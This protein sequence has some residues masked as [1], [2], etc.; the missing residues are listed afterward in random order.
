ML[1]DELYSKFNEN[2]II[3]DINL[4]PTF[5]YNYNNKI[6]TYFPDVYVKSIN[7]IY[8]VK[9]NYTFEKE[10]EKNMN[11]FEAVKKSKYNFILKV[12]KTKALSKNLL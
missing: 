10:Y 2:D 4:I 3:T 1:L 5:E 12:Y 6:K 8:E 11:K 7:T 9:S